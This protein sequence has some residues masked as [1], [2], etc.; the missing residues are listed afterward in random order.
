MTTSRTTW[1][2]TALTLAALMICPTGDL[3]AQELDWATSASAIQGNRIATDAAGNSYVTG[4]FEATATFGAGEANE[5]TLTSAGDWDIFVAKYDPD[6]ALIWAKRAGGSGLDR[7][8]GIATDSAGNSYV[9]GR[10]NGTATFGL[11]PNFTIITTVGGDDV[12]VAKYDPNGTLEWARRAGGA[13]ADQAWGIAIDSAGHSYVSGSFSGTATFGLDFPTETTLTAAGLQDIFVAKYGAG[14][15]L[16]WAN[17]A[18]STGFDEGR[19]IAADGAGNSYVSG[20]LSGTATFGAGEPNETTLSSAGGLDT[21][22]A[23]YDASGA[24][25]WAKR[26][27]GTG[28]DD[29]GFGIALDGAGNSYA[30]GRF[31]GTATFGAGEPNQTTLSSAGDL[32]FF[33]ARYDA[34]GALVWARRAGGNGFDDGLAIAT[35]GAGESYVIG[36]FNSTAT[37]GA[38]EANE[39]TLTTAGDREIF[40]ASYDASGALAWATSAGGAG[41]DAGIGIAIDGAGNSYATGF[42]QASATF[43]AGEANET[44]LTASGFTDTFIARFS[45]VV[46]TDGDGIADVDDNCPDDANANQLDTDLDGDGDACDADDDNDTVADSGDNCPLDANTNQADADG[47]GAGNACDADLDGDGVIDAT[48][49][50]VPTQTGA[51]VNADGCSI[52]DLVP[53]DSPWKNHGAYVSTIIKTAKEFL[54]LGL[55]TEAERDA[56]VS[57]AAQSQCGQ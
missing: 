15:A 17:R 20:N 18:G 11:A 3:A 44:T 21:F 26:A 9:T 22:V 49:A 53:C 52:A 30:S 8:N 51:V 1:F 33:V 29:G 35:D 55:I 13:G 46:D 7:G 36:F 6:G 14:G 32:D 56:I 37:F 16:V 45:G 23:R 12:F 57:A 39:T 2:R 19:D 50:C 38:G 47:D 48:D 24:L 5:T 40:V 43:G 4:L 28:A 10:F 42:F 31:R 41:V 27:G 25:L 34:S 54:D